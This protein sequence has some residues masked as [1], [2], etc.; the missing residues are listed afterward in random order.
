[1]V[2][3]IILN[4]GKIENWSILFAGRNFR[5]FR[6]WPFQSAKINSREKPFPL[7][8]EKF[9]NFSLNHKSYEKFYMGICN[10][11]TDNFITRIAHLFLKI[12]K[13]D[14]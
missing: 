5:G 6:G 3:K 8:R 12:R 7:I 2:Q 10:N 9:K 11:E 1:M 4:K 14:K 13:S